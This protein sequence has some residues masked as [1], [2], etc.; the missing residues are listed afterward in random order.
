MSKFMCVCGRNVG[1]PE[2]SAD[3]LGM[4]AAIGADSE[5]ECERVYAQTH[6]RYLRMCAG[7]VEGVGPTQNSIDMILV[8]ESPYTANICNSGYTHPFRETT[9]AFGYNP[10]A[11]KTD[12]TASVVSTVAAMGITCPRCATI[13]RGRLQCADQLEA[14]GVVLLNIFTR[15]TECN[16]C[17]FRMQMATSRFIAEYLAAFTLKPTLSL[18]LLGSSARGINDSIASTLRYYSDLRVTIKTT[19]H[20][21]VLARNPES[22]SEK[23]KEELRKAL[24]PFYDRVMPACT[25]CMIAR[26]MTNQSLKAIGPVTAHF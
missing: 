2:R 23:T 24:A 7:I 26:Y 6:L 1:V 5:D 20:P 25:Q 9:A 16:A 11:I 13:V 10:D 12:A 14:S 15:R 17:R 21:V 19:C 18:I 22:V 4:L 8:G 3:L